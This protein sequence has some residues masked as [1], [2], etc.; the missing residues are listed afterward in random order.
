MGRCCSSAVAIS[1]AIDF[2]EAAMGNPFALYWPYGSKTAEIRDRLSCCYEDS[3]VNS[4]R[5]F[6]KRTRKVW[7]LIMFRSSVKLYRTLFY[8]E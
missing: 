8:T 3:A 7:T 4:S 1:L 2:Y 6:A 5:E